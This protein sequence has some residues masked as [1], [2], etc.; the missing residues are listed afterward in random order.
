MMTEFSFLGELSIPL[1]LLQTGKFG[2]IRR[3]DSVFVMSKIRTDESP[4]YCPKEPIRRNEWNKG[5]S[6]I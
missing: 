5:G 4:I 2:L 6:Y 1:R 3:A